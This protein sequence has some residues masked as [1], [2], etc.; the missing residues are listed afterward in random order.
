[1]VVIAL[2]H[3]TLSVLAFASSWHSVLFYLGVPWS[4]VVAILS[5]LIGHMYGSSAGPVGLLLAALANFVLLA[6][7][8]VVIVANQDRDANMEPR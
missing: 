3:L 6:R 5:R 1:M 7:A 8:V 4:M 2:F